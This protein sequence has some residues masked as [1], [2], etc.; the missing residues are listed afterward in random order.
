MP[1]ENEMLMAFAKL[2][3]DIRALKAEV[4]ALQAILVKKQ[5]VS[6][7]ELHAILAEARSELQQE[8]ARHSLTK[9]IHKAPG[10]RKQ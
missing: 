9:L 10:G 6:E 2:E 5:V 8:L 4:L 3:I 7:A 1:E